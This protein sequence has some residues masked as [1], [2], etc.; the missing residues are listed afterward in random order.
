[1]Q[2]SF[3]ILFSILTV[4]ACNNGSS[5]KYQPVKDLKG[6]IRRISTYSYE[7]DIQKNRIIAKYGVP[8]PESVVIY[9]KYGSPEVSI[10]IQLP[11]NDDPQICYVTVD[12]VFYDKHNR[13]KGKHLY[14]IFVQPADLH[15]YEDPSVLLNLDNSFSVK[16]FV[17]VEV[18]DEKTKRVEEHISEFPNNL[19]KYKTLPNVMQ[20]AIHEWF[21]YRGIPID[22]F[23]SKDVRNDTTTF[24]YEYDKDKLIREREESS[25][26][27]NETVRKYDGENLIEE[28]RINDTDT[29]KTTYSYKN[30]KLFQKQEGETITNY[31]EQERVISRVRGDDQ[32]I[33]TY[34][35]TTTLST[36]HYVFTSSSKE[37][38]C[39]YFYRYNKDGLIL[40]S[41]DLNLKDSDLYLDDAILLFE[42]F[43][44]GL[45]D[46]GSLR[47]GMEAIILKIDDS[48]FNHVDKTDY[49]NYDS[50]GNPLRIIKTTTSLSNNYS[51]LSSFS[52][53][54]YYID[55]KV[56][57]HS[58]K[59]IL[60][61]EIEYYK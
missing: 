33:Y 42:N 3:F 16:R 20:K 40:F 58:Y 52:Y 35:D 44:D 31:D 6:E 24:I 57:E 61:R 56:T 18:S 46:E 29:S 43:R 45:I 23:D 47:K 49:S 55:K 27:V 4:I 5:L 41:A 11:D 37:M 59:R 17:R 50:H 22:I 60:E 21:D 34:K 25:R 38:N 39:V 30:G 48:D 13:M 15:S 10:D 8:I 53:L 7:S 19:D 9:N 51:Y 2:K 14:E 1:M 28:I 54:K 26:S 36:S 32:T 12:S